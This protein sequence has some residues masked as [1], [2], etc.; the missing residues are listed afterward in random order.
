M[1]EKYDKTQ[2]IRLV[3]VLFIGPF[4]IY[5]AYTTPGIG[6]TEKFLL[7]VIGLLTMLY[8]GDNYL[9]NIK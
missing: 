9:K 2:M 8:N 1:K 6:E 7:F 3:D 5:V 4:L